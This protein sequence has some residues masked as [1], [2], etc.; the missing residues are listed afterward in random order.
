MSENKDWTAMS[1]LRLGP[2]TEIAAR[3]IRPGIYHTLGCQCPGC[4]RAFAAKGRTAAEQVILDQA[5][6]EAAGRAQVTRELADC[7]AYPYRSAL[8][9]GA[10]DEPGDRHERRWIPAPCKCKP[11]V[12]TLDDHDPGCQFRVVNEAVRAVDEPGDCTCKPPAWNPGSPRWAAHDVK[13]PM[14]AR[15]CGE[16]ARKGYEDGLK[17]KAA[18]SASDPALTPEQE[19]RRELAAYDTWMVSGPEIPPW[20]DPSS[21]AAEPGKCRECHLGYAAQDGGLCT[22]CQL[23]T[24]VTRANT[25]RREL[26]AS[27]ERGMSRSGAAGLAM[28]SLGF[29]LSVLSVTVIPLDALFITGLV[30]IVTGIVLT[31]V[32][33]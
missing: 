12:W 21:I 27:Q 18:A 19:I 1:F 22:Y 20:M 5:Y 17:M 14:R 13:C 31:G 16:A 26:A 24:M 25:E 29:A 6:R 9:D 8:A 7:G 4:V 11:P 30:L 32:R 10:I 33:R 23:R 3:M 2:D 15:L 28:V